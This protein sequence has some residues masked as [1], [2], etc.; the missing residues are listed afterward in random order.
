VIECLYAGTKGTFR[1]PAL[2]GIGSCRAG[3]AQARAGTA[4][5][6]TISYD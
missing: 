4:A 3:D 1:S 6:R 2:D 5:A